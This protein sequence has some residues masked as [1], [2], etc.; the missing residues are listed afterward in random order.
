M[1]NLLNAQ[2]NKQQTH[3]DRAPNSVLVKINSDLTLGIRCI[4]P[5]SIGG[6]FPGKVYK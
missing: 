6:H 5:S 3:K 2:T 4:P 1:L